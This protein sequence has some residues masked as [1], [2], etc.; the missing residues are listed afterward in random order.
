[1]SNIREK[2]RAARTQIE[3]QLGVRQRQGKLR[4]KVDVLE[5]TS[6]IVIYP[7]TILPSDFDY[8]LKR[9][10]IVTEHDI[11]KKDNRELKITLDAIATQE[12]YAAGMIQLHQQSSFPA[13]FNTA[14][15][16]G[17]S[18]SSVG[19]NKR[20]LKSKPSEKSK[21]ITNSAHK[22]LA[23]IMVVKNKDKELLEQKTKDLKE[24]KIITNSGIYKRY[25]EIIGKIEKA[26]T[27][28]RRF[29]EQGTTS[30]NSNT[31]KEEYFY[32][33]RA[34]V[35]HRTSIKEGNNPYTYVT[36]GTSSPAS[37]AQRKNRKPG[38]KTIRILKFEP[39]DENSNE[40]IQ[41]A[42]ETVF[43]EMKDG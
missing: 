15:S 30:L 37:T 25:T 29:Y 21:S 38:L 40:N 42:N 27:E 36:K 32:N 4:T 41:I 6:K 22:I 1:M 28:K 35:K 31:L 43:L 16:E 33:K 19:I 8:S 9:E 23:E 11:D 7:S 24:Q 2:N 39:I 10:P 14:F 3:S 5:G 18:I 20:A 13:M 12:P 26:S 34:T 17:L